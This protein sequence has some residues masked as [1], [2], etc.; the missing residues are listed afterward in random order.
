MLNFELPSLE[1]RSAVLPKKSGGVRKI[2]I[3]NDDLKKVQ[4]DILQY[5]YKLRKDGY[6][7]IA[8]F[9]H[10][11]V[12]FKNTMTS[13]AKHPRES[14]CRLCCDV[15]DFFDNFP[16]EPVRMQLLNAGIP[17]GTVDKIIKACTYKGHFP[18][19]SPASPYLTNIGMFEVDLL[20]SSYAKANGFV[21]TRYADD[22]TFS[23]LPGNEPRERFKKDPETGERTDKR[24]VNPY[25][26]IFYGIET[27]LK[28]KLGLVLK[29]KK[30]HIIWKN[31]R[32]KPQ[33]LGVVIRSDNKGYN[34]PKKLRLK[35]RAIIHQLAKKIEKQHGK[36]KPADWGKWAEAKGAIMY[37]D[38]VRSFSDAESATADPIIQEKYFNYLESVFDKKGK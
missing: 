32:T 6:I 37:M 11:F 1:W 2:K 20:L 27:I 9:A 18:Q 38:Y 35:T 8:S 7:N 30:D 21:Y 34:A 12:P 33:V 15:K 26:D 23:L 22:I 17:E 28:N 29:H 10:G 36:T 19:G 16:I 13:I 31:S 3:P 14:Q 4:R 24:V 5:L 25:M